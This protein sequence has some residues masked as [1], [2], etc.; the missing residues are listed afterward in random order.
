MLK[1]YSCENCKR[2]ML[3]RKSALWNKLS[4]LTHEIRQLTYR[5]TL[6]NSCSLPFR[7]KMKLALK[8]VALGDAIVYK[9]PLSFL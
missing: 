5:G 9:L 2:M 1:L 8:R 4:H 3:E 6:L 7:V